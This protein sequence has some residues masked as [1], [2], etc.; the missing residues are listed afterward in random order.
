[1]PGAVGAAAADPARRPF[2]LV[3]DGAFQMTGVELATLVRLGTDAIVLLLDNAN[4]KM[5]EVMDGPRDYYR[6]GGWD[7][8]AVARALGAAAE[9]VTTAPELLAALR[10]A[11]AARGPYLVQA[12][13]DPHDH[14]P[15]M[16]RLRARIAARA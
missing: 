6:L 9:R 11:E 14:A 13:L 4:Y 2:V 15:I 12:V 16:R 5:L 8:A 3:G 7:Y 10:R 1:M